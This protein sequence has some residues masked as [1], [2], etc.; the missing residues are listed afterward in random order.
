MK[1]KFKF[2]YLIILIGVSFSSF[3]QQQKEIKL[4][5]EKVKKF[6]VYIE[7]KHGGPQ[8]FLEWKEN[9]NALYTNELWYYSESFYIK[10]NV[11]NQGVTM[12]ESQIDIS[13]FESLRKPNE[14]VIIESPGFKDAIVLIPS[15][16]LI[17]KPK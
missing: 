3:S 13:R 12:D 6:I 1:T 16:K 5:S 8:G 9:N 2:F 4:D 15:N 11:A 17:Y 7:Y 10:R 14:E